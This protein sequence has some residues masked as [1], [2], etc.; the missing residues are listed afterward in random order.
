[1]EEQQ[2]Q[3]VDPIVRRRQSAAFLYDWVSAMIF[4]LMVPV[5]LFTLFIRIV[6][7]EGSSMDDTLQDDD[8]LVLL[9][10]VETFE[11]GDIVVV[12]RY[13]EEPLIKR[14]IAVAGDTVE[15]TGDG[16]VYLNGERLVEPYAK[17]ATYP[18]AMGGQLR[19]P[20]GHVFVLGDNRPISKDS[21]SADVGLVP[22]EDVVGKA[23]CRL[24]PLSAIGSIYDN[25]PEEGGSYD[26]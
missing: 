19:V 15:I 8:H 5:L 4:A 23:V 10:A 21:R 20:E 6:T 24:W 3:S 1:M 11:Y 26:G 14:V 2:Q 7:V 13:T 9:T 25:L 16:Q 18:N 12:D 17:G 22:V